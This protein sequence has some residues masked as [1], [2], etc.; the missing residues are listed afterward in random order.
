MGI[1]KLNT[2]E[3]QN[4]WKLLKGFL[5]KRYKGPLINPAYV[6]YFFIVIVLVGSFGMFKDLIEME[7]CWH[8]GFDTEKIRNFCFNI[9]STGLSLVTASVIDLIFISRK[10][11]EKDTE[12]DNFNIWE[13]E[14]IKRST[15][16]FGLGSLIVT[17]VI[18]ILVNTIF[19]GNLIR[20]LFAIVA[21]VFSYFIWWISNVRNKLLNSDFNNFAPLGRENT[22]NLTQSANPNLGSSSSTNNGKELTG[23][24]ADFKI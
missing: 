14:S 8:C 19:K 20:L 6:F 5:K 12:G 16:I 3:K 9:S 10:T 18:W 13:H 4:D 21:L 22:G 7:W 24:T 1:D 23:D 15:R 2:M 17:F 11:I